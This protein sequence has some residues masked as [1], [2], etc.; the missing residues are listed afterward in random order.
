MTEAALDAASDDSILIY[1][2]PVY[3]LGNSLDYKRF[4]QE[5]VHYDPNREKVP[6]SSKSIVE[7]ME[8]VLKVFDPTHFH[9][10][11]GCEFD[12]Y[13][14]HFADP[15][16]ETRRAAVAAFAILT[17]VWETGSATSFMPQHERKYTGG[18]APH[19]PYFFELD[20]YIRAFHKDLET[21]REEFPVM[22]AYIIYALD[23]LDE[24]SKIG[25]ERKFPEMDAEMFRHFRDDV[26]LPH[27]QMK[28]RLPPFDELMAELG[29]NSS[30]SP[31]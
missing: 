6:I 15:D 16:P 22:T 12:H 24:R 30:C 5:R 31:W 19:T 10:G 18:F 11:W 13:E 1:C 4:L 14:R 26:L 27:R 20:G 21:I 2:S 8:D 7:K 9:G 23:V 3:Y 29:W 28:K 25:L 17:G